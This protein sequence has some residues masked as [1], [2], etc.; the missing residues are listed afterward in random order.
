M[1]EGQKRLILDLQLRGR[2]LVVFGW[3]DKASASARGTKQV[4]RADLRQ[5][6]KEYVAPEV[7]GVSPAEDEKG[8]KVDL[9]PKKD[10][11]EGGGVKGKMPKWLKGLG[12][13]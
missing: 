1:V 10:E 5:Q 8:V 13:K 11:G 3:D 7:S 4:L 6:A 2:V 9:G 12:K